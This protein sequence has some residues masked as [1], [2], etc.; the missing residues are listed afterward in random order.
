MLIYKQH[1]LQAVC[2]TQVDYSGKQLKS[3]SKSCQERSVCELNQGSSTCSVTSNNARCIYCCDEKRCN[4][5]VVLLNFEK[6]GNDKGRRKRSS[7]SN[8]GYDAEE[9]KV[10]HGKSNVIE[11]MYLKDAN[12][13]EHEKRIKKRSIFQEGSLG[14]WNGTVPKC[15][16]KKISFLLV[17]K[18]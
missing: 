17:T 2:Q 11:S 4:R 6:P 18:Y 7:G 10:D 15:I 3:I 12:R 1:Y 16:G 14:K 13:E 8:F 9:N 5:D